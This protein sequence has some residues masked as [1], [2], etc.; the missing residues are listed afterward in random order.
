MNKEAR[1]HNSKAKPLNLILLILCLMVKFYQQ[2]SSQMDC[3]FRGATSDQDWCEI[4]QRFLLKR[5]SVRL[6][7][8]ATCS[9]NVGTLR[10]LGPGWNEATG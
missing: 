10:G 1:P 8:D 3:R 9:R 5:T 6:A 7:W 4:L 2:D